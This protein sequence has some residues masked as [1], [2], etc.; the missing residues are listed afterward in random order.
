MTV[1]VQA[2]TLLN[3]FTWHSGVVLVI[4]H[5]YSCFWLF[6]CNWFG[7]FQVVKTKK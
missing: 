1:R 2:H 7:V 3:M 4:F 5:P 6:F